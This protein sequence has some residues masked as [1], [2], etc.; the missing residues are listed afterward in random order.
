MAFQI[1]LTAVLRLVN[2]RTGVTPGRLFQIS[3]SRVPS[4]LAANFPNSASVVNCPV[5]SGSP[6]TA[7]ACAVMLSSR[8]IVNVVMF[9]LRPLALPLTVHLFPFLDL[10]P[11]IGIEQGIKMQ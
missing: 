3:I 11:Q 6:A 10:T 5:P 1:R 9:V 4:Q 8:S 7:V 2:L